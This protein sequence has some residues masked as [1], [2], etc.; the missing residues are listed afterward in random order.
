MIQE[1]Y[2]TARSLLGE[3]IAALH[4]VAERLL[5]KEVLD[6][7]EVEAIVKAY[8]DGK[9][10]ETPAA[11]APQASPDGSP[12]PAEVARE[13]PEKAPQEDRGGVPGL[14]PKPV[15]A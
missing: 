14:P 15:L 5:E 4:A 7:S 11:E 6:G 13:K 1:G 9:V 3:N 10:P 12:R 2:D 8:K